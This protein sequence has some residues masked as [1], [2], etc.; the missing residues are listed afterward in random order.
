MTNHLFSVFAISGWWA[1]QQLQLATIKL[2]V[3]QIDL[4]FPYNHSCF[5]NNHPIPFLLQ[6]KQLLSKQLPSYSRLRMQGIPSLHP[7][8]LYFQNRLY[9]Q[10]TNL[11][12]KPQ[13]WKEMS[14][15]SLLVRQLIDQA[16]SLSVPP[17]SIALK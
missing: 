10:T 4:V 16:I 13:S 7:V 6:W 12:R 15:Q 11:E 5:C 17:V 8:I 2:S 1:R 14:E 3:Y 9:P